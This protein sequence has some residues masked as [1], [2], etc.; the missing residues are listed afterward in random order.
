M[1][2]IAFD[3]GGSGGKMFLGKFTGSSISLHT[4][5]R[6][7]HAAVSVNNGLYWD[8][9]KIYQELCKGLKKAVEET[10]DQ[11][12]SFG[13]DS[14][15][16]DFA[17]VS[18]EGSL[19][20]QM[21]S[22][23]DERTTRHLEELYRIMPE[24]ELYQ[25]TG[26]QNAPFNCLMQLGTMVLQ[27]QTPLFQDNTLL[28]LPD[29]LLYCM[30]GIRKTEYTI[31]SVSQ[32]FDFSANDWNQEILKKFSIPRDI[33]APIASP[34]TLLGKTAGTFNQEL[35]T[36]GFP[37]A[38]VCEHDT[39]SAF[40]ASSGLPNSAIISCGTWAIVGTEISTPIINDYGFKYNIAN[41]GSVKN[42]H[43][44]L[45]NVMGTWLLQEIRAE[46]RLQGIDYSY[47]EM[48]TAALSA[49]PFAYLIDVDDEIFYSPGQMTERIQQYCLRR[50]GSAPSALGELVRCVNESLAMK[51]RW[52]IE[53][54][55]GLTGIKFETVNMIGGGSQ[56]SLMCQFTAN[57]MNLPVISGPAE[58]TALGNMIV[59]LMAHKK[60]DTIAQGRKL[61]NDSFAV[62]NYLPID[63]QEWEKQYLAFKNSFL[64]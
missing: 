3:I 45:K 40:L 20:T 53:K 15:C 28:F 59:Q 17:L 14:F 39:S 55:A 49:S 58:A 18:P 42:H 9:I 8:V 61:I 34:G 32:M 26:N 11:I 4:L 21:H 12:D 37:A 5:H 62:K 63:A 52:N 22:Y 35:G 33:F 13:I 38:T 27:N 54:I 23:R 25:A 6:F 16:N 30:T 31:A 41:E 56:S 36:A 2:I 51:Y 43:R 7:E 50:Y 10:G 64:L 29:L 48:E 47:T 46:Y 57:V 44:I 19:V 1:N 24:K 60:I